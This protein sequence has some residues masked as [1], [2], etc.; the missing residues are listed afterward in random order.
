MTGLRRLIPPTPRGVIMAPLDR[1]ANVRGREVTGAVFRSPDA[2]D[3][4]ACTVDNTAE[5][6]RVMIPGGSMKMYGLLDL[7][8]VGGGQ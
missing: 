4:V 5:G 7:Q 6:A 2:S 1:P 8:T 3:E